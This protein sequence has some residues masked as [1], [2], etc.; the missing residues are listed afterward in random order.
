MKLSIVICTFNRC[1][2]LEQLLEDLTLQ[3]AALDAEKAKQVE[4]VLIDN[5][6]FDNTNEVAYRFIES[7]GLSIKYFT[8]TKLGLSAARNLAVTKTSGDLIAFLHDDI[9][10]DENWLEQA[11]SLAD[12]C[13]DHEIGVYG[14]RVIPMWQDDF[15]TWL[16]LEQPYGA[17]QKVFGA[18]SY[19]DVEQSYP[20]N[21]EFGVA[22]TPSGTNVFIRKEIFENCG[23]FRTDL[24]PSAAG[25]FGLLD[26]YEFFEYLSTLKIPM[27]YVPELMVYHP[28]NPS[29]MTIQNIRRWYYK[30]ARAHYWISHTDRMRRE[31]HDLLGIAPRYRKF[32]PSIFKE[33][34]LGVPAF[35]FLKFLVLAIYWL[36]S[37]LNFDSKKLNWLSY[38]ISETMGEI[39]AAALV[40]EQTGT[41]KFS[42][43]DRLL[44]KGLLSS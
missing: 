30:S 27:L 26:D 14:G 34:I 20:F 1:E 4:L 40:Q 2:E 35:L 17:D 3:H 8:E 11:Y 31:P 15:P 10:L 37:H 24:G 36:F 25:G 29:M 22:E 44:K 32:T 23:N 9:S 21:T 16:S 41:R 39:D 43:K 12:E 33:S 28:I 5:N 42:F 6:S 13:N 38:K 18:H 7:T 19:G